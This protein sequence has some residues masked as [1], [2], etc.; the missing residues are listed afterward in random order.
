MRSVNWD[1][2]SA[3]G[4]WLGAIATFL[5][6]VLALYPYFKKI[7]LYFTINSNIDIGHVL[8]IVNESSNI[9]VIEKIQFFSGPVFCGNMLYEENFI[10][11]QDDLVSDKI[12]PYIEPRT[13]RKVTFDGIRIIHGMTHSDYR[14]NIHKLHNLRI[15]IKSN[16]GNRV[17]NTH[18]KTMFFLE[19]T[20]GSLNCY[21]NYDIKDILGKK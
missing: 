3:V 7:K 20:I 18:I 5:A 19:K 11:Y 21:S 17:I 10:E 16:L 6:A 1:A 15:K 8:T 13:F 12:D 4:S 14:Y 9:V 2:V